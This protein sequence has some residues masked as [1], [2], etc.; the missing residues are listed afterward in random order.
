MAPYSV[1]TLASCPT[2]LLGVGFFIWLPMCI[3]FGRRPAILLSAFTMFAASLKAGYADNFHQLLAAVCFIGLAAGA[4]LSTVSFGI[5]L[6]FFF[7]SFFP[8]SRIQGTGQTSNTLCL[9]FNRDYRPH[10]HSRA[11]S[12]YCSILGY[13]RMAIV[14]RVGLAS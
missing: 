10:F 8:S 7:P 6:F 9:D 12:G 5:S 2:L 11:P 4:T 14:D 1:D 13:P 3:A